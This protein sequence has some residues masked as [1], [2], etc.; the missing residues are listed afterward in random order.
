MMRLSAEGDML[1]GMD[2]VFKNEVVDKYAL[3]VT[4]LI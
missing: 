4:A 2:D 1:I 3:E